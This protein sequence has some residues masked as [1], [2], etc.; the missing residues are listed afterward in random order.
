VPNNT[1]TATN[2]SVPSNTA[3]ATPCTVS[4]SDVQPSDYFYQPVQYLACRGVLGGYSDGTFR[5]Y[6]P[7]T[8]GQLAKIVVL[9]FAVPL[10]TPAAGGYTFA[11]TPPGSTF[12]PS[13][14]TAAAGGLVS[15]YPC[16]GINPQ[17]GTPEPCDG[18][19]RPYYR[20]ATS[21]T[22]GQLSKIVVGAA[23]SARGWTLITPPTPTFRDVAG[24]STFFTYVET[25]VCHGMITGYSDG[26]FRP[27]A[28]AT[29]GQ[30]SKIVYYA[31]GSGEACGTAATPPAAR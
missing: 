16:G 1:A 3:T 28:P 7:T 19:H 10:Q 11:D 14:E 8:R 29:R 24:G 9:A 23:I 20:P 22:R 6:N 4:F 5:P 31:L 15:G 27:S 26:T 13:I 25:A 12:F 2:T 18:G 17:T 21:V 30:I